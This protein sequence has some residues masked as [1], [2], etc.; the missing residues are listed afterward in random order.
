MLRTIAAVLVEDFTPF[1]LGVVCEVFGVDRT[2][3]GGPAFDFRVCGERPGE[4]LQCDQGFAVV[5]SAGLTGLIDADLVIV[6]AAAVRG[7]YAPAVLDALRAAA[8]NRNTTLLSVCSGAYLLG[9]AGL[10]DGRRCT[11]HWR[12]IEDFQ[13]RF[14]RADVDPDVLFVDDGSIV[15]SAGTAAGIDACLHLVRR[16]IGSA[17][18]NLIARRMVVAPH[19]EGGQRQFIE[20]PVPVTAGTSLQP[21]LD[22]ILDDLTVEHTVPELARRASM[23]TR[24]LLRRFT[25]ETGTTPHRWLTL[26]RIRHAQHLLE[27]TTLDVEQ[28][29]RATGMGTGPLLRHHFRR[30]VGVTPTEYRATFAARTTDPGPDRHD[31]L[32]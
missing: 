15:T 30:I 24:T 1:E 8:A 31:G 21:V 27:D 9:A 28:I 11:T 26:Q 2:S 19:R 22:D 6:P 29:A 7:D 14:P 32:S 23:S 17:A 16:E 13:R 12:Y 25:A 10:L 18:A 20:Q 3:E 4:P 5:P